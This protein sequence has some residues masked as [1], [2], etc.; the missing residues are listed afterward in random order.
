MREGII[1]WKRESIADGRILALYKTV[2]TPSESR[3]FL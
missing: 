1:Y 3:V 2:N